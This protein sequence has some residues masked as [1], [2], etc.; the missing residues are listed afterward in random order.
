MTVL[1]A[2]VGGVKLKRV[3]ESVM[4]TLPD[5]DEIDAELIVVPEGA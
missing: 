4:L 2:L 5:P 1:P 3:L